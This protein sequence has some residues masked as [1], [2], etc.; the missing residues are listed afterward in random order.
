MLFRVLALFLILP[1]LAVE[2]ELDLLSHPSKLSR[3][4]DKVV[5]MG[6]VAVDDQFVLVGEQGIVLEWKARD[7]WIQ[8]QTPV[9]VALTAITSLPDGTKIAVGQDGII[10]V[11]HADNKS[12]NK[13]FD[14]FQLN[15]LQLLQLQSHYEQLVNHQSKEHDTDFDNEAREEQLEEL[16]YSILDSQAELQAGPSKPLLTVSH[17]HESVFAA[18]AYGTLLISHDQGRSWQ[19]SDHLVDNPDKYHLNAI[20]SSSDGRVYLVGENG[21]AFMSN[22]HG[23][24][25]STLDL[26]YEGSLFGLLVQG[27]Q[28]VAFGLQG[29]ILLS[30]NSGKDWRF[31][32][33]PTRASLLGGMINT[34]N[35]VVLVG[36]GGV[37]VTFPLHNPDKVKVFKH[38]SGAAFSA[39]AQQAEHLILIGQFG[40]TT[41]DPEQ[42]YFGYE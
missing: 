22:N 6:M 3:L 29:N 5:L 18:G 10:L 36:H 33:A 26:P 20:S 37:I 39:V 31:V 24:H 42:E 25:W 30:D 19:L 7:H 38:P 1:V 17:S 28:I 41:W 15:Q 27:Q 13:A 16:K 9:S 4:A 21:L 35:D 11:R 8:Q 40:V 34:N 23:Q 14:G 12:W 32:S 2:P